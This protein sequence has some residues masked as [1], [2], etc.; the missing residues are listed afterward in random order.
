MI[1]LFSRNSHLHH[2]HLQP[3]VRTEQAWLVQNTLMLQVSRWSPGWYCRLHLL[4]APHPPDS[5]PCQLLDHVPRS[6]GC[7]PQVW[8]IADEVF[9]A[10]ERTKHWI[11]FEDNSQ[12]C[13]DTAQAGKYLSTLAEE[14]NLNYWCSMLY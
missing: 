3:S 6:Q 9:E 14:K 4:P 10:T 5:S 13:G 11:R 1:S 8:N 2:D 7:S 12:L